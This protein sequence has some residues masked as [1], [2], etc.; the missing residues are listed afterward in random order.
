M[1]L[2]VHAV[3]ADE[4]SLLEVEQATPAKWDTTVASCYVEYVGQSRIDGAQ[5]II[6]TSMA[7]VLNHDHK[8]Q[9]SCVCAAPIDKQSDL[10]EYYPTITLLLGLHC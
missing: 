7:A 8:L 1:R 10:P 2:C 6:S 3:P 5:G 4:D 9:E